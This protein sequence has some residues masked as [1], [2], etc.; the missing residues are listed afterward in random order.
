[1]TV[2]EVSTYLSLS[3]RS[4]YKLV[5]DLRALRI[6]GRWRFRASDVDQWILKQQT[7]SEA[8]VEPVEEL[9]SQT[10]L[11][12]HMDETNIFLDVAGSD[13]SSLIRNGIQPAGWV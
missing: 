1:M 13:A 7:A 5:G 3:A 4:V 12:S 6:G 10:R 8:Q 2:A 11:F 9:A